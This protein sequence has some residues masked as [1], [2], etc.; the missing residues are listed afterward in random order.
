M[1]QEVEEPPT[2]GAV[3]WPPC[4]QTLAPGVAAAATAHLSWEQADT[5][6]RLLAAAETAGAFFL[7]DGTGTGKSRV[8]AAAAAHGGGRGRPSLRVTVNGA[9]ERQ[10]REEAAAFFGSNVGLETTTYKKLLYRPVPADPELL[11][12]LDEAHV[13]RNSRGLVARSL[14]AWQLQAKAVVY[15]TATPASDVRSLGYM[16]RLGL[17]GASSGL[18]PDFDAFVRAV[19][20]WGLDALELVGVEL[21]QRGLYACR[22]LKANV[23]AEALRVDLELPQQRLFDKCASAGHGFQRRLLASFKVQALLSRLREDLAAG[24]Q[25]VVSL[26]GTGAAVEDGSYLVARAPPDVGDASL[27]PPDAIDVLVGAFGRDEVAELSG[28]KRRSGG[29][30]KE[31]AL[32]RSGKKR[33]AVVTAAGG[34]GLNLTAPRP[35]RHYFAELPWT[36][37]AFLQQYGRTFRASSLAE[38]ERYVV[39]TAAH[40]DAHATNVLH[41][42][43]RRLSALAR[44]DRSCLGAAAAL[45]GAPSQQVAHAASAAVETFRLAQGLP[46]AMRVPPAPYRGA[47]GEREMAQLEGLLRDIDCASAPALVLDLLGAALPKIPAAGAALFPW[48]PSAHL[49]FAPHARMQVGVATRVLHRRFLPAPLIRN[50]LEFAYGGATSALPALEPGAFERVA[51]Q[52]YAVQRFVAGVL[53]STEAEIEATRQEPQTFEAYFRTRRGAVPTGM[54]LTVLAVEESDG[55]WQ[56]NLLVQDALAPVQRPRLWV[57]Q[58]KLVHE[59][60]DGLLCYAAC[61]AAHARGASAAVKNSLPATSLKRWKQLEAQRLDGRRTRASLLSRRLTLASRGCLELFKD[62]CGLVVRDYVSGQLR[63]GLVLSDEPLLRC[64][65]PGTQGEEAAKQIVKSPFPCERRD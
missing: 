49:A 50:I 35:V 14:H 20:S 57:E 28:R 62:S 40:L 30:A 32:F 6:R 10:A 63:V 34:L 22:Q 31:A 19:N 53:R 18:F 46:P 23:S 58:G 59:R 36:A 17:W 60:D 64:G 55:R 3:P 21:K 41:S 61:A 51:R 65:S 27:L 33:V 7:G 5:A 54:R 15:S 44:S 56:V 24:R 37:E 2:L 29:N 9:L 25:V 13:L 8:L 45:D 16:H 39:L 26:Q 12:I 48:T 38:P 42:R 52:P 11:L 47:A 43:S 4:H 1:L